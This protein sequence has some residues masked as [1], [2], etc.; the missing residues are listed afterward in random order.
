MAPETVQ[1]I[2]ASTP[3]IQDNTFVLSTTN[4]NSLVPMPFEI[5]RY[6]TNQVRA[7]INKLEREALGDIKSLDI[8][9]Y[10]HNVH[11]TVLEAWQILHSTESINPFASLLEIIVHP[12]NTNHIQVVR[13]LLEKVHVWLDVKE[14]ELQQKDREYSPL[15]GFS[16]GAMLDFNISVAEMPVKIHQYVDQEI[17]KLFQAWSGYKVLRRTLQ[18]YE[19]NQTPRFGTIVYKHGMQRCNGDFGSTLECDARVEILHFDT[20]GCRYLVRYRDVVGWTP[21]SIV[22]QKVRLLIHSYTSAQL[23]HFQI[24]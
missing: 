6:K 15:L 23:K 18:K 17:Q 10:C 20:V 14:E 24:E 16:K 13:Q 12:I 8:K 19:Q 4:I 3:N 9:T 1:K 11:S 7:S 21:C 5:K 22:S 2:L